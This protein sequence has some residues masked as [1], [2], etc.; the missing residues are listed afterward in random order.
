MLRLSHLG[1]LALCL[2]LALGEGANA[3]DPSPTDLRVLR[4]VPQARAAAARPTN[5][6]STDDDK[7]AAG[8]E[9]SRRTTKQRLQQPATRY[10]RN[11]TQTPSRYQKPVQA[12][13][14]EP[15]VK[16]DS[17]TRASV[18][19]RTT[20]SRTVPERTRPSR[21]HEVRK[22]P[23]TESA[24]RPE[25][26]QP[27]REQLTGALAAMGMQAPYDL[28]G[29]GRFMVATQRGGVGLAVCDIIRQ[30]RLHGLQDSRRGYALVAISR[31]ARWIAAVRRDDPDHIDLWRADNGLLVRT[32]EAAGGAKKTLS[33][34]ADGKLE[35][36]PQN[37]N[38]LMLA[39]PSG[40]V[41]GGFGVSSGTG[42]ASRRPRVQTAP[43]ISVSPEAATTR[44][45]SDSP[46]AIRRPEQG[47]SASPE[48]S[49]I[50]QPKRYAPL[51]A[52]PEPSE[53]A[54]SPMPKRYGPIDAAPEPRTATASPQPQ[55]APEAAR[56]MAAPKAA[57]KMAAPKAEPKIA[58]PQPA[59]PDPTAMPY[60]AEAAPAEEA[61]TAAAPKAFQPQAAPRMAQPQE[62]PPRTTFDDV[63]GALPEPTAA[64]P[65]APAPSVEAPSAATAAPRMSS[66]SPK[67]RSGAPR[68]GSGMSSS[69]AAPKED[70][71]AAAPQ[72]AQ[73]AE[74]P[75][76]EPTLAEPPGTT[77]G[78]DAV[79]SAPA[80]PSNSQFAPEIER[81]VES[82]PKLASAPPEDPSKV[83]V[84]FATNRNRLAAEDR[85]FLVYFK[86]FFSSL[87]AFVIYALVIVSALVLPWFGK[88]RW[89]MVA[90]AGGA[91]VLCSMA[92]L[93]AYI[94]S[95][96]RDELTGEFY[97]SRVT[98]LSYGVCDVSVPLPENRQRGEVNRPVEV[99][100]FQAP[101]NPEKHF[102][103]QHVE[104][105]ENES[106]FYKSL[107][108]QVLAS[109][110]KSALLF[111]HGYNVS[112]ESA[113]F[114]TAQLAVDLDF[115]GAAIT[116][117][118]PSC[119]DPVKYT[120]DE[121]HAEVSIP[122]L[123]E[124]LEDIVAK[125]GAERIHVIAHSMGNRVLAGAMRAMTPEARVR[126]KNKIREVVLAA[127]DIDSRVFK[128]QILP[129]I[130]DNTQHC[131]L[132]ASSR[133][134]ALL[135]SRYFHNYQRLGETEP[136]LIVA[137][138]MDTIDASL[139]DTSLLGHSYIG[140]A[141]SIV[142][143]LHELVVRNKRP[144]ERLGL[145][146]LKYGNLMYWT[147]RPLETASDSD[148][149]R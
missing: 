20:P 44:P 46:R 62:V 87:P 89:G 61:P 102:M 149:R 105:H 17:G 29:S 51:E 60:E 99:W 145:E 134:R 117:S 114:R 7:A 57:P 141:Q 48:P 33:F 8:D 30:R 38:G 133:D 82:A 59:G 101:A 37:G 45:D 121:Q 138:G 65:S 74:A 64:A 55:M 131:T 49:T 26:G 103:L 2:G 39:V 12:R 116:Y 123:R 15:A 142:S 147:I 53:A 5:V 68:E 35:V 88:R 22:E 132:Y 108:S 136:D 66:S 32:V 75:V 92:G 67:I 81:S 110:S 109:D 58:T 6:T 139:V 9:S 104:E 85:E 93:E 115:G 36:L 34:S 120:F 94:R 14:A 119:A 78:G 40:T 100:V 127:P 98:D 106:E 124:V 135:I 73:T 113:V 43:R 25:D 144:V 111:I 83:R 41:V 27:S 84:H 96:L 137:D 42:M 19:E 56:R 70:A 107:S 63:A 148:V 128:T 130:V 71:G 146:A 24:R 76:N 13:P 10:L 47:I 77:T 112:F 129:H 86:G 122:A 72:P 69:A 4:S 21:S 79:T 11:P 50:A 125:S 52:S 90:V 23:V 95:Q 31:D 91:L 54:D 28:S 97:G 1:L 143:D 118:W 3:A 126:N 140:D 18:P 80:A 16:R